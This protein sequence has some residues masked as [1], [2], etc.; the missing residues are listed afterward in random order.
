MQIEAIILDMDGLLIDS[1]PHWRTAIVNVMTNMG[2]HFTREMARSTMGLRLDQVVA[3]WYEKLGWEGPTQQE[4][5]D[6]THQEVIRLV[7]TE[8]RVMPGISELI[9]LAT[10]YKLKL[11]L[12]TS[13]DQLIAHNFLKKINISDQL[14]AVCTGDQVTNAKPHPEIFLACADKLKTH[15]TRCLVF[16]DSLNGV[17]AAKAARMRVVAVPEPDLLQDPRFSIAEVTLSSL[18]EFT[19]SMLLERF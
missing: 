19:E 17:I 1:E 9:T 11:G 15:F 12:A 16:E 13:S 7:M 6:A 8:G 3:H 2:L 18:E 4:V 5:V 14:D 10:K